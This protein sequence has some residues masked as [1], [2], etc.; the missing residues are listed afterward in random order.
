LCMAIVD[1]ADSVLIDEAR[2]PFVL[3]GSYRDTLAEQRYRNAL[4]LA[5]GLRPG[6]HFKMNPA[7]ADVRVELTELGQQICSNS[8]A[9]FCR[10][11]PLWNNCRSRDELIE[12][13]LGALHGY[14]KDVHY[15]VCENPQ[16][17]CT[18]IAIIDATTGRV[19]QGRRW[20]N[21][22]HQL[23]ELKEA[24]PLSPAQQTLAQLTYQ[25][26][27]P[28][29]WHLCGLSGTLREARHEL[30]RVY[31]LHVEEV[32]LRRPCQRRYSAPHIHLHSD[33]RWSSV[34]HTAQQFQAAGRPVL[35]GTD[36]VADSEY[37]V[38]RLSALR[39]EYQRLD[40]RQDQ[41]EAQLISQAGLPGCVT[42]ATNMA[43][44][45]TDIT[46]SAFVAEQGG[47]HVIVCQQNVSARIDRQL[48][49]RAARGGD[50][51]SV[52]IELALDQGLLARR[53]PPSLRRWLAH[54]FQGSGQ[55]HPL[56]ARALL[57]CVQSMEEQRARDQRAQ[58]LEMDRKTV[59][60]L[61]FGARVE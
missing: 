45:G 32:R 35:I 53:L 27:F 50:P 61:G 57:W 60:S 44:R 17:H 55:L 48:Q 33:T 20:S 56:L 3:A 23:I 42:V 2:V 40:A 59:R 21:G 22:L 34:A 43:G 31:G 9:S 11:D 36:S 15:L 14:H 16:T 26:F 37:L 30:H 46:I 39:V 28:R 6:D 18:E 19:A 12:L 24:C 51:G 10:H 8:A 25:R 54:F 13:A 52:S 47:L 29:Y 58:L 38:E 1:E 7:L 49:G 41:E 5:R 4:A